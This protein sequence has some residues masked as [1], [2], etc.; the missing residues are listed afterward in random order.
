MLLCSCN[1]NTPPHTQNQE[2]RRTCV[3]RDYVS[4]ED[5]SVVKYR[6]VG[7]HHHRTKQY[8]FVVKV[9]GVQ[10]VGHNRPT[11]LLALLQGQALHVM[12]PLRTDQRDYQIVLPDSVLT[13]D[14]KDVVEARVLQ[15]LET[16]VH[17]NE[18]SSA[19]DGRCRSTRDAGHGRAA[20]HTIHCVHLP[21]VSHRR[22]KTH[23]AR[24]EERRGERTGS[25][26]LRRFRL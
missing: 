20:V 25:F 23:T 21:V 1:A 9:G 22:E 15:N 6:N 19:T 10:N 3:C 14:A 12:L 5:G 16:E 24:E 17:G 7:Y 2:H 4:V 13:A 8:R 26:S 11:R 18:T